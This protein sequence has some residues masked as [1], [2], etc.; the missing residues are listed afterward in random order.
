MRSGW[1]LLVV[2]AVLAGASDAYARRPG[3][4]GA[5]R[6]RFFT[7]EIPPASQGGEVRVG[8][9]LPLGAKIAR[10]EVFIDSED[11]GDRKGWAKCNIK[12]KACTIADARIL[13]FHRESGEQW[14]QLAVDVENSAEQSRFVKL[15]VLFQPQSG[16]DRSGCSRNNKRCGLS[17]PVE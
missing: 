7:A 2:L 16:F 15:S 14:Q 5:L 1:M 17:G 3:T 12:T 13:R 11:K 9:K 4:E 6:L 8:V 10:T